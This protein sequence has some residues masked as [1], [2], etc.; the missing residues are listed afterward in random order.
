MERPHTQTTPSERALIAKYASGAGVAVAIGTYEGVTTCVMAAAISKDGIVY[1]VDPFLK[2]RMGICY[3]RWI[4]RRSLRKKGFLDRV[5]FIEM[6]SFEA[7]KYIDGDIDFIFID[8]DH[9][10]EG[11]QRDWQ[12]WAPKVRL[13]G[14][15]ALHDTSVPPHN[16]RVADLGSHKYFH[17]KVKHDPR[18]E[19]VDTVDSLNVLRRKC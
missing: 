6:F 11:F 2:G 16:P 4:T 9:S 18:F 1:A 17:E 15:V 5:R 13:G 14:G 19:I 8:G 12:D 7:V 3:G 10:W